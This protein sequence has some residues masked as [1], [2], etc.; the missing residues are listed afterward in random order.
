LLHISADCEGWDGLDRE[1]SCGIRRMAE[2][3][4][5]IVWLCHCFSFDIPQKWSC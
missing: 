1:N 2:S 3:K 4:A 5:D